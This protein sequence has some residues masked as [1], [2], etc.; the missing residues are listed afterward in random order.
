MNLPASVLGVTLLVTMITIFSSRN[1]LSLK[2]LYRSSSKK[3]SLR[4][5]KGLLPRMRLQTSPKVSFNPKRNLYNL[6]PSTNFLKTDSNSNIPADFSCVEYDSR[7]ASQISLCPVIKTGVASEYWKEEIATIGACSGVEDELSTAEVMVPNTT[8][9][10]LD[11]EQLHPLLIMWKLLILNHSAKIKLNSSKNS[12]VGPPLY[13]DLPYGKMIGNAEECN[14]VYLLGS[15]IFSNFIDVRIPIHSEQNREQRTDP[16]N[17]QKSTNRARKPTS[18]RHCRRSAVDRVARPPRVARGTV[19]R[20]TQKLRATR[21]EKQRGFANREENQTY[22]ARKPSSGH[23]CR[24]SI[25]NGVARPAR[26]TRGTR[27]TRLSEALSN[28][29]REI[30]ENHDSLSIEVFGEEVRQ[31]RRRGFRRR[32]PLA[33]EPTAATPPD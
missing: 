8:V 20:V 17:P 12:L 18:G 14:S 16:E 9:L 13:L 23:R 1:A 30:E 10:R 31:L 32:A 24:R 29:R 25:V 19:Q 5:G 15:Y 2:L 7:A 4:E 33:S 27:P 6:F 22:R 28:Q 11:M 3:A 26:V 21:A